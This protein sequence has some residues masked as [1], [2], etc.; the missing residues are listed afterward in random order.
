MDK[1]SKETV[2]ILIVITGLAILSILLSRMGDYLNYWNVNGLPFWQA[3]WLFVV[4]HVWPLIKIAS[5][6]VSIGAIIGM[7]DS[8]RKLV[9]VVKAENE[10]YHKGETDLPLAENFE[11]KNERWEKVKELMKSDSPSGW[12]QAILDADIMLDELLRKEVYHG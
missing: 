9:R 1:E 12:R 2:D 10:L 7:L 5:V 6:I 3:L 4:L 8:R 11:E